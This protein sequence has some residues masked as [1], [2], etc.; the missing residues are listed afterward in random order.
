MKAE[1]LPKAIYEK[2]KEL[3]VDKIVLKF[4]GGSDEGELY[5]ETNLD[6]YAFERVI[7][8]WA[9]EVYDYSGAGEGIGYGDDIEYD[10]KNGKVSTS[11]WYHV[12]QEQKGGTTKLKVEEE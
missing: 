12:V 3:G 6:N 8:D 7:E 2:A 5:V 1:P 10:L 11:E 9:W 4:S